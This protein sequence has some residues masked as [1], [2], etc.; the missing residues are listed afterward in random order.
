MFNNVKSEDVTRLANQ[1]Q[2]RSYSS[3]GF[4]LHTDESNLISHPE[5]ADDKTSKLATSNG[6]VK[7]GLTLKSLTDVS[8]N[9]IQETEE[10]TEKNVGH[11]HLQID[12]DHPG[13]I[14]K[15]EFRG[16]TLKI[17]SGKHDKGFI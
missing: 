2:P 15:M 14:R 1:E 6:N 11:I 7:H 5:T 13:D 12:D 10:T 9:N 17:L 4:H 8:E 16:E 3:S